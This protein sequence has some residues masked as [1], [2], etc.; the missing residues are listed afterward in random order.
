MDWVMILNQIFQVAILPLIGACAVYLVTLINAKK[1]EIEESIENEKAKEYLNMLNETITNCVI[2]TSQT[3]VEA[4]K[5]KNAFDEEAQKAALQ[6]TFDAVMAII[7]EDAKMYLMKLVGD[8]NQY[9]YT[10]IE[11]QV[12]VTK[13][14]YF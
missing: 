7:S 6:M 10:G 12:A 4:L 11:S 5:N 3:Y 8:L 2:T 1:K 9:I 14:V 13:K